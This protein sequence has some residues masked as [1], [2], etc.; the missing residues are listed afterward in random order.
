MKILSLFTFIFLSLNL[1]AQSKNELESQILK[2]NTDIQSLK[3][4]LSTSQTKAL[5][6]T[7]KIEEYST[8]LDESRSK[9]ES[10]TEDKVNMMERQNKLIAQNQQ[11]Q[12]QVDSL[13]SLHAQV[14][15]G[16]ITNPK[17]AQ[18][19]IRMIIQQ[20]RLR[21][22]ISERIQ[23]VDQNSLTLNRMKSYYA[24][25]ISSK[26]IKANEIGFGNQ[27]GEYTEVFCDDAKYYV[28]KVN[29]NYLIHWEA[30]VGFNDVSLAAYMSNRSSSP[31]ELKVTA[32]LGEA[33]SYNYRDKEAQYLCVEMR[34]L[35]NFVYGY[36]LR[37]SALGKKLIELLADGNKHR[38][39]VQ[40]TSDRSDDESGY[41]NTI[42]KLISESWLEK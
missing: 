30:S 36:V 2:L 41:T 40:I 35:N 34:D 5:E 20:Y 33:Y 3:T 7:K 10:C 27:V 11:L 17:N 21:A 29:G 23:F 16:T 37:S 39:I 24:N 13:I 18:D 12:L 15:S 1:I 32:Q 26:E 25:G 6:L 9:Y 8:K 38:I 19:S 14:N 4:E 42:N 22:S 28:K 31:V